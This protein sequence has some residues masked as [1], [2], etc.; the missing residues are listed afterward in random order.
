MMVVGDFPKLVQDMYNVRMD[1][2]GDLFYWSQ[3]Y[4]PLQTFVA[5]VN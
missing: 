2:V 5:Y 3:Y 1:A 4:R